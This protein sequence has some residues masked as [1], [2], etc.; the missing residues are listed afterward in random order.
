M[1]VIEL[2]SG[3][4][5]AVTER[6]WRLKQWAEPHLWVISTTGL[7]LSIPLVFAGE[8]DKMRLL[9]YS[10]RMREKLVAQ[11]SDGAHSEL[12]SKL[13]SLD[14]GSSAKEEEEF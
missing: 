3:V 14:T 7:V 2:I 13:I 12:D 8:V 1:A 9:D 5:N 6:V 4:V 10:G 11:K